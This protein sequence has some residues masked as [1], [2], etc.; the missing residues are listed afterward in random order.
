MWYIRIVPF[1]CTQ[2]TRVWT[3]ITWFANSKSVHPWELAPSASCS[4]VAGRDGTTPLEMALIAGAAGVFVLSCI[5]MGI[6]KKQGIPQ[7]QVQ[8][9]EFAQSRAE[10]RKEVRRGMRYHHRKG[11]D[12]ICCR[13][14]PHEEFQYRKC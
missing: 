5:W 7:D 2:V 14:C 4:G 9:M 3:L 1:V 10:A 11:C 8:A 6:I 12:E 13:L